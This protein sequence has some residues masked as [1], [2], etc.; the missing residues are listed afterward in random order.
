MAI[1]KA[2]ATTPA[3]QPMQLDF[4]HLLSNGDEDYSQRFLYIDLLPLFSA[5][6]REVDTARPTSMKVM[7]EGK[8]YVLTV[9]PAVFEEAD[10]TLRYCLPSHREELVIDSLRKLIASGEG[11]VESH[12]LKVSVSLYQIAHE[13]KLRGWTFN[14]GSIREALQI[15]Q[16]T[17]FCSGTIGKRD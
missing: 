11:K 12:K 15:C 17:T 14:C 16:E 9:K 2:L 10:G 1:R 6:Q 7:Y 8:P 4:F 5:R 13:L 3:E